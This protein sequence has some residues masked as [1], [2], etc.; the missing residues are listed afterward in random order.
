MLGRLA[1]EAAEVAR[2]SAEE[3]GRGGDVAGQIL[4]STRRRFVHVDEVD[5]GRVIELLAAELAE[6]EHA[7]TQRGV[8][9]A[10]VPPA[11]RRATRRGLLHRQPP[12]AVEQRVGEMRELGESALGLPLR[13]Q[14]GRQVAHG[15]ARQLV[16]LEGAQR[17]AGV[18]EGIAGEK[19]AEAALVIVAAAF[20]AQVIGRQGRHPCGMPFEQRG[21][22][23]RGAAELRHD[24]ADQ[25]GLLAPDGRES[26]ARCRGAQD[27][28]RE[29]ARQLGNGAGCQGRL[30]TRGEPG[31]AQFLLEPAQLGVALHEVASSV[32]AICEI[33]IS[34]VPA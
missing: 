25:I 20:A 13:H 17:G 19:R 28:G 8:A 10:P 33:W 1:D 3:L 6:A 27:A 31:K 4:G 5:I 24:P 15:D 18:G 16:V 34:S 22:E 32:R 29:V 7:E 26:A 23:R 30:Q 9:P 21:E 11:R 14:I 12:G 2:R